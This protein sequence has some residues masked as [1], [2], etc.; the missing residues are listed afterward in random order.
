MAGTVGELGERLD[1]GNIADRARG[2]VRDATIGTIEGKVEEMTT[3]ASDFASDAGRTAQEA[4]SGLIETI[5]QNPVPAAM[6]GIGIGW[7]VMNRRSAPN[8][9][10]SGEWDRRRGSMRWA[11][12]S[13]FED[14]SATEDWTQRAGEIPDAIGRRAEGAGEAIGDAA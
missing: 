11:D 14:R 7:L 8:R 10:W 4:G 12:T 3:A 13:R 2:R 9:Q 5:R 1:P 6:A